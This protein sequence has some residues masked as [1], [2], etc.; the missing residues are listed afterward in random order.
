LVGA[1]GERARS[2]RR[3]NAQEIERLVVEALASLLARPEL[4]SEAASASWSAETR[5]LVRDNVERIVVGQDELHLIRK[6]GSPPSDEPGEKDAEARTCTLAL[7]TARRRA[8]KEII[9]PGG[10]DRPAVRANHALVLAIARARTWMHDLRSGK[11]ADTEEISR[12]LKLNDAHVRRL[13][14]LAY[15]APDIVEAVVEGRQPHSLTVR[16]LL[17]GIPCSWSEQRRAF[18]LAP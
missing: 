4:L 1:S 10:R 2:Q 5:I 12:R 8:Y 3:I 14:R 18:G 17:Q 13:L 7:P 9:I 16:R 11:Y 6:I 15:L